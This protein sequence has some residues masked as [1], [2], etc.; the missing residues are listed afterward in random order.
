MNTGCFQIY[1]GDGKGKTTAAVGLAVRAAGAGLRVFIGQF[2]KATDSAE[3]T[4]LRARCPEITIEQFGLGRF[5]K[6][7]PSPDDLDMAARGMQRLQECIRSGEYDV[8][9][10]DEAHGALSAGLVALS[11][12]VRL[13]DTRPKN[14][15]LVMTGRNAHSDLLS[16][17]DLI[18]E[19]TKVK[20]M[21]DAG[22]PARKG[23]EY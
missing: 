20:H 8:I 15:E 14:V 17:A 9:I 2:I 6:G 21:Y 23:I 12:L 18:T 13:V 4:L 7:S 10:V 16:R 22:I 3:M 1:T 19:M 11:D 5:I